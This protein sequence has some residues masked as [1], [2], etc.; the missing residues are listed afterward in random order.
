LPKAIFAAGVGSSRYTSGFD[1]TQS[2]R[3]YVVAGLGSI[4]LELSELFVVSIEL[5][6]VPLI[7]AIA[8]GTAQDLVLCFEKP[9]G[10]ITYLVCVHP[11]IPSAFGRAKGTRSL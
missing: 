1:G 7:Q 3:I 4:T 2:S 5:G 8:S 11:F 9:R 6:G 10:A